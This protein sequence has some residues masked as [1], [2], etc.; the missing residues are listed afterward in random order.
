MFMFNHQ[1]YKSTLTVPALMLKTQEDPGISGILIWKV[2]FHI[3]SYV[4]FF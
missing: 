2:N 1:V 3:L 4:N